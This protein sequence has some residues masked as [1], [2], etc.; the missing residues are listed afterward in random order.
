VNGRG[1][2]AGWSAA[3]LLGASCGP[4]DAPVE[5]ITPAYR[6]R[7]P[8]LLVRRDR[9]AR[10]EITAV[11]GIA[12]TSSARTAYD[13]VRWTPLVEGVIAVDALARVGGFHPELLRELDR[14]HLGAR[15]SG[16]LA[17]VLR[18]ANPLAGSPMETRIRLAILGA[19]LPVPVLQFPVGPYFLDLAYPAIG[20]AIEYDGRE[21]LITERA[22]R[23]WTGRPTSPPPVGRRCCG[24]GPPRSTGRPWSR[25]GCV[26]SSPATVT[27]TASP[28]P[29]SSR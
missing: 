16:N 25:P 24:S 2:L 11:D 27:A 22:M 26:A 5:V 12:V 13:L 19:G 28:W 6:R 1:V 18:L 20:L 23:D 8:G 3:E 14:R 7:Q 9:L 17:A 15:G 21:H 4:R 10:D 29:R